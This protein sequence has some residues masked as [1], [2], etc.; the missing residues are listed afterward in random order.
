MMGQISK[1]WRARLSQRR[2]RAFLVVIVACALVVPWTPLAAG[3]EPDD[4]YQSLVSADTPAAQY[5]LAD[6]VGS[7][8]LADSAGSNTATNSGITLGGEGPFGGSKSGA[9]GGSAYAS[10]PANPIE[11]ASEF[12]F[13]AWVKWTGGASY[14]QAIFDFS[15]GSNYISLTPASSLS[16]HKMT[17][18]FHAPSGSGQVSAPKL[19]SGTWKYVVVT[20]R[21][22]TFSL[23]VNGELAGENGAFFNQSSLTTSNNYLGK[24]HL[25]GEPLFNGSLSN[26][27]FYRSGL[28]ASQVQAHYNAAE[29]PVNTVAP[30][31]TGTAKDGKELTAKAGTWIGL[32][33]IA[34]TYQWL[35]CNGAGE[36]CANLGTPTTETKRKLNSEDV[37]ATLRVAVKAENTAGEGTATSAQ[38][39][40]VEAIKPTNTSLP[41]V[42]GAPVDGKELAAVPGTWEGTPPISYGYQWERCGSTGTG[43]KGLTGQTGTKYVVV[44][45]DIGSTLRVKVTATNAGG[46]L[47]KSSEVTAVVS[48]G[49]PINAGAPTITGTLTDGQTVKAEPGSWTGTAPLSYAY[50][51]LRC[52]PSPSPVGMTGFGVGTLDPQRLAVD[53]RGDVWV[54]ETFNNRVVEFNSDGEQLRVIGSEGTG[55]GRFRSPE[56]IAFSGGYIWVADARNLRLE[57]FTEAGVYQSEVSVA[58]RPSGLAVANG[59]IWIA[60]WETD[61]IEELQEDGSVIRTFGSGGGGPG[62]LSF[63]GSTPIG[64]AV[65]SDEAVW[66]ADPGNDRIEKFGADGSYLAQVGEEGNG[67]GEFVNPQ[68]LAIDRDGNIWVVDVAHDRLEEFT[69]SGTF[70]R[71][72]GEYGTASGQFK[73]PTDV[74]TSAIGT[75][76]VADS[77]NARIQAFTGLAEPLL[78]NACTRIAGATG[79][80]YSLAD[81]DVEDRL[82]VEVTATNGQGSATTRSSMSGAVSAATAPANLTLPS[83]SGAPVDG[84]TLVATAGTWHSQGQASY[85]YAWQS[86][87]ASGGECAPVQF[88]T[89]AS[90]SLRAGDI[91]TTLRVVVTATNAVG[92]MQATSATTTVIAAA[93]PDELQAPSIT[94]TP[95]ESHVLS[96]DPGLWSGTGATTAYQWESCAPSGG[97]C[98][99]I[100]GAVAPEYPLTQGDVGT[101]LRVRIGT[102]TRPASV[103]DVSPVS[104]VIVSDGPIADVTAPNLSGVAEVGQTLQVEHGR[105]VGQG[106]SYSYRWQSCD[107]FGG[108]CEN[109]TATGTSYKAVTGV[110]GK[111]LRVLVTASNFEGSQTIPSNLTQPVATSNAPR[112][113]SAPIAHGTPLAGQTLTASTGVWVNPG[114]SYSYQWERCD[115]NSCSAIA[116]AAS[117]A[118]TLTTSDLGHVLRVRVTTGSSASISAPTATVTPA[119][120]IKASAP[121]IVGSVQPG[122]TLEALPGIWTGLGELHYAFAWNRCDL[123]GEECHPIAGATDTT[124]EVTAEDRGSTLRVEV[125]AALGSEEEAVLTPRTVA[126]LG[127]EVTAEEAQALADELDPALLAPAIGATV[128]ES[129]LAPSLTD[130][131]EELAGDQVLTSVTVS[132]DAPD[133]FAINTPVG[134]VAVAPSEAAA[135]ATTLPT[136]VNEATAIFANVFP[137]TD[138]IVRPNVDGITNILDVRSAEA[139]RSFRWEVRLGPDQELQKLASGAVAVVQLANEATEASAPPPESPTTLDPDE[140]QP[141]TTAEEAEREYE[142]SEPQSEEE[143]PLETLPSAPQTTTAGG[144]APSGLPSPNQT[145]AQYESEQGEMSAAESSTGGKAQMTFVVPSATDANGSQVPA[146]LSAAGNDL[147]LTVKPLPETSYPLLASMSATAPTD[148]VSKERD[149]VVYGLSDQT[150][151]AF[152]PFD[153]NL[154]T[155]PLEVERA[156]LAI[157]YDALTKRTEERETALVAQHKAVMTARKR[158]E[159]WLSAVESDGLQPFITLE[160]DGAVQRLCNEGKTEKEGCKPPSTGEYSAG[161]LK[162]MQKAP[163]VKIW[164]A[165]KEPDLTGPLVRHAAYAAEL[166]ELAKST[167]VKRAHC[168]SCTIV[169]GE[170][171]YASGF[172]PEYTSKY[173]NSLLCRR[174]TPRCIHYWSG[175]PP[176]VWGF[177]DY[178]DVVHR[179]KHVAEAFQTFTQ[180]RGLGRPKVW[181]TEAGVELRN[182]HAP[183]ELDGEPPSAEQLLHQQQAAFSILYLNEDFPRLARI[184]Y[185]EYRQP[186]EAERKDHENPSLFDSGLLEAVNEGGPYGNKGNGRPAYCVLA[187][188]TNKC[189]PPTALTGGNVYPPPIT[190]R[191]P[192]Q[193]RLQGD[194][195]PNGAATSFYFQY[196]DTEDYGK[197]TPT[198]S[199][200]AGVGMV[201]HEFEIFQRSLPEASCAGE[202]SGHYRIV[203]ESEGGTS[204]GEDRA[205]YA[206][207]D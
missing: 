52:A 173:R 120:L 134:E 17:F 97:E 49:P 111:R 203:A 158:L 199:A 72:V 110:A 176:A 198:E 153:S 70:L 154:S 106:L 24:S 99:P 93:G 3:S 44:S 53:A 165:W 79:Q 168:K 50:Q 27:A 67:P 169:A 181:I 166:W 86:C 192:E 115:G 119:T 89:Q 112:P 31:I 145:Q 20:Q 64:L 174:G 92:S 7:S 81:A 98:A 189:P 54:L 78:A 45:A 128:E 127:G 2:G 73:R 33:P 117:S 66:V 104:Q 36:A 130:A 18:E 15:A 163:H 131:G 65:S 13:E 91:G 94:G 74:A 114:A 62:Q 34:F 35:R 206:C 39:A 4:S 57:K 178:Q 90:Y 157:P 105:W 138:A 103:S 21:G 28:T 148:Q 149:P 160:S 43:C 42:S 125:T 204:Y 147:T 122:S 150:P 55:P 161:L 207:P 186:S 11:G 196:G 201:E 41:T 48:A 77:Q 40:L 121:S 9:F 185:Y 16:G 132:K 144:E 37:G 190:T 82:A 5:R 164:G 129:S 23:Y 124:Y 84:Q 59:H 135:A 126:V 188:K 191:Y 167:A 101:T 46:T 156:R 175:P 182:G 83:I 75:V 19:T 58:K 200:G 10:L 22:A 102:G 197:T 172:L 56:A 96:A 60:S 88:A 139:P 26:V 51:W 107:V 14:N 109:L 183:T 30:S 179:Y 187:Y 108:G 143:V 177:H 29:K 152:S 87:N 136:V 85:E 80:T 116:G 71:Q 151:E 195:N 38:T 184:Y 25:S 137:A 6:P 1:R 133:S 142:A 141:A 159:A 194:I 100:E 170:F 76:W 63:Q 47:S 61:Q 69:S 95:A 140:G 8:T 118:Y 123:A 68:G 193:L 155:G 12:T 171:A 113:E 162:L 202:P 180:G 32:S 205:I 146:E